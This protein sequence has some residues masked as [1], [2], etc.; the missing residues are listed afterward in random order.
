MW[1]NWRAA[2]SVA[3]SKGTFHWGTHAKCDT[4]AGTLAVALAWALACSANLLARLSLVSSQDNCHCW[5]RM[6]AA[7]G[8]KAME[9]D[10][11]SAVASNILLLCQVLSMSTNMQV[12][13]TRGWA[14]NGN[15]LA[16]SSS[17]SLSLC[18]A[19]FGGVAIAHTCDMKILFKRLQR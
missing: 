11:G 1:I 13:C 17:A 15:L 14:H 16:S 5:W 6:N 19:W 7:R 9:G 18:P 2:I 10:G 12:R 8:V 4:Q 3:H